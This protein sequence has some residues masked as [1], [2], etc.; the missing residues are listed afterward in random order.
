[1]R[2]EQKNRKN[3]PKNPPI[4]IKKKFQKT[5]NSE[6]VVTF[7]SYSPIFSAEK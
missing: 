4:K 1:M 3:E 2:N 6:T 7:Q 5:K